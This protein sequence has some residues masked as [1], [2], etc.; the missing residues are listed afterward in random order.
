MN[1]KTRRENPA[2]RKKA[3]V[4]IRSLLTDLG[5]Q[6][7]QVRVRARKSLVAI[8]GPAVRPLV[9]TLANKREWCRWE[10]AKTLRQIGDAGATRALIK[11][12]DD[13]MFDVRWL[14]AEGLIA[15]GRE[16]LVP[17]LE[18]LINHA[19]SLWLREGAHHVL[20]DT[21]QRGLAG[22][23]RPVIRALEGVEPSVEA[24]LA[25]RKAI[26]ALTWG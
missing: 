24:P 7:G 15:I 17:L 18:A 9:K 20:H 10:A 21:N 16:A 26:E 2:P 5:S 23:L 1:N 4:T 19:D 25:A 12:L 3:A 6:D 13:R 8:G 11:A 14:A 22:I